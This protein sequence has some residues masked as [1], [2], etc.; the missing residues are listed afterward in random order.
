MNPGDDEKESTCCRVS[1]PRRTGTRTFLKM[2][3]AAVA[4]VSHV[5][6]PKK[7][8]ERSSN[9][10]NKAEQRSSCCEDAIAKPRCGRRRVLMLVL[11][12]LLPGY[13]LWRSKRSPSR[14]TRSRSSRVRL[15]LLAE[16]LE[17]LL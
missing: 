12:L 9:I 5:E 16:Q 3:G 6:W 4:Y 15:L 8:S 14:F 17:K 11:V 7:T 1:P 13:A 2:R 10:L